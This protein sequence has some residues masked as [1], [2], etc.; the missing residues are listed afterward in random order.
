MKKIAFLLL[1]LLSGCGIGEAETIRLGGADDASP[2]SQNTPALVA[3]GDSITQSPVSNPYP[4]IL[5][6]LLMS[7]IVNLGEGG[8]TSQRGVET[9]AGA[10]QTHHPMHVLVLY[11]INDILQGISLETTLENLRTILRAAKKKE[12]TPILATLTPVYGPNYDS[13]L[14]IIA[15]LN[16]K[17]RQLAE[18]EKIPLADLAAYPWKENLFLDGIHPT[19]EGNQVIASIFFDVLKER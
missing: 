1:F 9:I 8:A 14:S 18:E 10:L 2:V 6:S 13:Y 7:K 5:A 16:E 15:R 11:G 12:G 17:I 19:S 3:L 4:V